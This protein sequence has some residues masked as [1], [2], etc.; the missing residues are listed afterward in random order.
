MAPYQSEAS[1][2]LFKKQANASA[3]SGGS[4]GGT[5]VVALLSAQWTSPGDILS[6]LLL[7]GP[8]IVQRAVAQLAGRAV[9]P[10]AFSFGWVAYAA[11]ALLST[12]GDGLLMPET[13]IAN[14]NVIGA[15]SG[16]VRTTSSWVLGR[17]LRDED[18]R[19]DDKM[20]DEQDHQP[21]PPGNS[22]S[23][24]SPVPVITENTARQ[25]PK[26]EAL[27]ITVYDVDKSPPCAHGV[28]T[29]DRVWWSGV[30][31]IITELVI[32]IIPWILYNDW[33][34][35]MVAAAGN[36]LALISAS[37]PQWRAEKWSCP[38]TGGATV[39]ITQ[40]N[41]SR[42]AMVILNSRKDKVGLDLE[43]L[44]RGTRTAASSPFTKA[45]STLLTCLW[46]VL[47]I[48]VSGL[49][50]NT[51]FLLCIGALGSIQNLYAAG[52][53]RQPGALGIHLKYKE[54]I[55][56]ARVATVLREVEEKYP[57]VGVSLV[58][59]FFPGSLRAKGDDLEFWRSA[60]RARL[61]PNKFGTRIDE[62]LAFQQIM[63]DAEDAGES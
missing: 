23:K 32:S 63:P 15:D 22:P 16:H 3:N 5:G 42:H 60:M 35:F 37:L 26:W 51:W 43:I 14:T 46:V 49:K 41:G 28:P 30:V 4:S 59:V 40:G 52:S 45:I 6:V 31:V 38:K 44:A 8:E 55:S 13:D 27:R 62:T 48:N 25:R 39:T 61:A 54:T 34:P 17:L 56:H 19:I 20:K 7:L 11:A 50:E 29:L 18:D 36:T 33:G 9:T 12:F 53:S 58:P 57:T 10:V 47:L 1:S 21:P 24:E 2:L